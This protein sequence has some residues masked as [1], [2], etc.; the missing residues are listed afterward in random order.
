MQRSLLRR[1]LQLPTL[2]VELLLRSAAGRASAPHPAA[3]QH[4]FC[5]RR[6]PPT[7]LLHLLSLLLVVQLVDMYLYEFALG[8]HML[9]LLLSI[10]LGIVL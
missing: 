9:C 10:A 4:Q 3:L 5:F 7:L 2:G 1:L 6:N 8:T